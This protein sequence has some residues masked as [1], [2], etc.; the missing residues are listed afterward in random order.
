ML[1]AAHSQGHQREPCPKGVAKVVGTGG[2]HAQGVRQQ[3]HQHQGHDHREIDTQHETQAFVLR[4]E[5]SMR[6]VGDGGQTG[7]GTGEGQASGLSCSALFWPSAD[8]ADRAQNPVMSPQV[9][10]RAYD[11]GLGLVARQAGA[12]RRIL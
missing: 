12:A 5:A 8:A 10:A 2:Q 9:V 3:S 6:W 7:P 11:P 1:I 4:H